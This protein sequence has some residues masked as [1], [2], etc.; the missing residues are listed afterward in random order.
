MLDTF[1]LEEARAEEKRQ[2]DELNKYD[3]IKFELPAYDSVSF[4]QMPTGSVEL[5]FGKY[6]TEVEINISEHGFVLNYSDR[7][8]EIEKGGVWKDFAKIFADFHREVTSERCGQCK[9]IFPA[10]GTECKCE[11][12]S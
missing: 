3:E 8:I 7:N 9:Q 11:E 2:I 10:D 4:W 12:Q 5:S 1:E 6:S